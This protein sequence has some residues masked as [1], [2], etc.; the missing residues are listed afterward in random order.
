MRKM[1]VIASGVVKELI[2]R[3]DFYLIFALL[4]VIMLYAAMISFGG[5]R[6]FYRYFKEIGISLTYVF[7]L[8]IAVTFASRQ[9]PQEIEQKTIYPILAHPVSRLDLILGKFAG[10][11][12]ISMISFSLFYIVFIIS[13]LM[14]GDFT[15]PALLFIEGYV[16]HCFLLSF[17]VS[18]AVLFSLFLSPAACAGI[19]LILYFASN[20]FGVNAAGYIYLPHPELFDIKERIVHSWDIVPLWAMGLLC[21]YA[22]IYTSLFL[23]LAYAAFRRRDL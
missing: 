9:I 12:F 23:S 6:G 14:R 21:L 7:S 18:L 1:L 13:V 10:V 5:E 4:V 20:W 11:L 19:T 8:I 16:L 22:I 3:K 15:T 17:F 2:R